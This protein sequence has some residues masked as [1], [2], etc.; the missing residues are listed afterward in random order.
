VTHP[1]V[2]LRREALRRYGVSSR[3]VAAELGVAPSTYDD[4]RAAEGTRTLHRGV[5]AL[6]DVEVVAEQRIAAAL[7]AVGGGAVAGGPTAAYLLGLEA[8]CPTSTRVLV[9]ATRRAPSLARVEVVRTR[10]LEARDRT[11]ARR[12]PCTT[13][14]RTV[15]DLLVERGP[16]RDGLAV[17]LTA[18][19]R[20]LVT[21]GELGETVERAGPRRGRPL[22]R[23]LERLTERSPD[24]IFEHLV[25]EA[26]AREGM[27]PVVGLAIRV[28]GE[29]FVLDLAFPDE[30]VAVEC[31]GFAFHRTPGD[32]ARDHARQNALVRA[33]WRV[34]RIS[35]QRWSQEPEAVVAEILELLL[36]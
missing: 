18:L 13:A 6:P 2:R 34:L 1:H 9:P 7:L 32:L 15:L 10:H 35:W 29:R 27:A 25:A 11:V 12:L 14:E 17:V 30:K 31:D 26:L 36:G 33:G 4:W 20:G 28:G 19:Q 16:G 22:G 24:S 23:V 8:S 21:V 5:V 3:Q